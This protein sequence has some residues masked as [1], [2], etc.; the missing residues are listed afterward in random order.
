MEFLQ[1][2]LGVKRIDLARSAVHKQKDAVLR[3][4][5][6]V[7]GFG[8]E[9]IDGISDRSSGGTGVLHQITQGQDAESH[10]TLG[11]HLSARLIEHIS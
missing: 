8:S 2:G 1:R 4:G 9:L 3:L 11:E 10:A 7:L 6:K 5:W